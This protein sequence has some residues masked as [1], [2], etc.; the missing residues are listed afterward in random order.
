M[1]ADLSRYYSAYYGGR[2]GFTAQFCARRRLR[3]INRYRK[4]GHLKLLDIGCGEGTF[5]LA[6]RAAGWEVAGTE[7]N[8]ALAR[9]NRLDVHATLQETAPFAPFDCI[10][11]W[12]SLEHMR[13]PRSIV[14][15]ARELLALGGTLL[16]A[17]P[18][19]AGWQA[20]IFGAHWLHRD[21]PRHLYHFGPTALGSL[22]EREGFTV[23]HFWNQEF[24]YDLLGWSQS[25]LNAISGTPN[26]FFSTI[27]GRKPNAKVLARF[28]NVLGGVVF[29]AIALPLVPLGALAQA[30]GTLVVAARKK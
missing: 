22:L 30:G 11:L 2:H 17:V 15:K 14:A 18:N 28:A 19:A 6:A 1:P 16:V 3:W 27:T 4:A 29:S 10:T 12:H 5:L 26:L 23:T 20:R 21:V 8:P 13:D 24:E 9:A 7:M 25:A